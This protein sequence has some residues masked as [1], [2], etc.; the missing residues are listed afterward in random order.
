MMDH[1]MI[2]SRDL[3]GEKEVFASVIC[4][5]GWLECDVIAF[6]SGNVSS[7]LILPGKDL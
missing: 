7:S 1:R 4:M 2:H 5:R 3:A 6:E